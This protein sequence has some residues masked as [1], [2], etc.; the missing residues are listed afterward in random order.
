MASKDM[1]RIVIILSVIFS[2]LASNAQTWNFSV[3]PTSE[4]CFNE[5]DGSIDIT[6]TGTLSNLTFTWDVYDT[7]NLVTP[8]GSGTVGQ[9]SPDIKEF[10]DAGGY[11]VVVTQVGS[12]LT[13]FRNV[14]VDGSTTLLSVIKAVTAQNDCNAGSG[15][16]VQVTATNGTGPYTYYLATGL[17][18]DEPSANS[19]EDNDGLFEGLSAGS[20]LAWVK[21]DF[22]CIKRNNSGTF[23]ITQPD[24]ITIQYDTINADCSN[25]GGQIDLLSI[26]GGTPFAT[27]TTI[28]PFNYNVKWYDDQGTELATFSNLASLAGLISGQ[29]SVIISDSNNCTGSKQFQLSKGFF[30]EISN[31]QNVS[32]AN[33]NDGYIEVTLGSDSENDEAPFELRLYDGDN[34][35][36]TAQFKTNIPKDSIVRFGGLS[37]DNYRIEVLAK[38]TG[39]NLV[40][41]DTLTQPDA[42]QLDKATMSPVIC[43]TENTGSIKFEVSR[44]SGNGYQYSVDGGVSY[45]TNPTISGLAAGTYD[46]WIKDD[47]GCEVDVENIIVTEPQYR[48]AL[49][50]VA[51]SDITC[52]GA[53]DGVFTFRFDPSFDINPVVEDDSIRW[54]NVDTNEIIATG[55]FSKTDLDE[56]SYRIEVKANS[57][58]YR[59]LTFAISEPAVLSISGNAPQFNCPESLS[60]TPTDIYAEITGGNPPYSFE[61]KKNGLALGAETVNNNATNTTLQGIGDNTT[62]T[63]FVEDSKGCKTSKAFTVEIPEEIQIVINSKTNVACRGEATGAIDITVT[64]GTQNS[65]GSYNFTWSKDG[66]EI[67]FTEDLNDL[68]AGTYAL[69]ITDDNFCGPVDTTIVITQ[70]ATAYS[71]SGVVTPVICN[72]EASGTIN[73]IV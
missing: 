20:Y 44:G 33:K 19:F 50:Q 14:N 28:R 21:D 11:R 12:A 23:Q 18:T 1:K 69:S 10:L 71:I 15:A 66:L 73:V 27:T 30:L 2:G 38:G 64:G 57:G 34:K 4:T 31:R 16:I 72:G 46:L 5:G 24:A 42:P 48:W 63:L 32:C 26:T 58:C 68:V 56:G 54:R 7:A 67:A 52:N 53:K 22:G 8:I 65:Q 36:I 60:S 35:E 3:T 70:P 45:S 59:E 40:L 39:C 41:Y 51:V 62:Y 9:F 61:W 25:V 43:K 29:Y 55:V 13:R 37:A 6:M 17:G 49:E 47:S